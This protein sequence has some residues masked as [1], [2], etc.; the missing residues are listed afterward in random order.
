[1]H[2]C[3]ALRRPE[4]DDDDGYPE[5]SPMGFGG[6]DDHPETNL[7]DSRH[8]LSGIGNWRGMQ[9][10]YSGPGGRSCTHCITSYCCVY[11]LRAVHPC[12]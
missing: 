3:S 10:E 1:M 11:A 7:T 6:R 5:R 4:E 8:L 12:R 2:T 9:M